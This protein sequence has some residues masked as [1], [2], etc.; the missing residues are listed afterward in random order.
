MDRE[1]LALCDRLWILTREN[2]IPWTLKSNTWRRAGSVA[3]SAN[4]TFEA[5][6]DDMNLTLWQEKNSDTGVWALYTAFLEVENGEGSFT[7][8]EGWKGWKRIFQLH[9]IAHMFLLC[10]HE[11][12]ARR[13]AEQ[14]ATDK[15]LVAKLSSKLANH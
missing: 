15:R 14:R 7:M 12:W 11:E 13:E 10:R 1:K 4:R 9:P 6:V 2:R 8:S 5:V 3:V